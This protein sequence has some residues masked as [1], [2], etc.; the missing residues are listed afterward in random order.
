MKVSFK[1][2]GKKIEVDVKE[3]RGLKKGTGLMFKNKRTQARLFDFG[4]PTREAITSLFCFFDFVAVFLDDKNKVVDLRIVKPFIPIIRPKKQFVRLVE[5]PINEKN[6][7]IIKF[8]VGL[9]KI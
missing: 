9:Q 3:C 4:K 5:I 1:Y 6:K 7:E 8:L 2:K